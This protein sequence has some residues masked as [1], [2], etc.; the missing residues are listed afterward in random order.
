MI[1]H[2]SSVFAFYTNSYDFY[3][4]KLHNIYRPQNFFRE[5]SDYRLSVVGCRTIGSFSPDHPRVV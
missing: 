3:S 5:A 2:E 1:R 4:P